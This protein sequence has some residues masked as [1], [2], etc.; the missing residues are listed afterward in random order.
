MIA[1]GIRTTLMLL[2]MFVLLWTIWRIPAPRARSWSLVALLTIPAMAT[3]VYGLLWTYLGEKNISIYLAYTLLELTIVLLL[4]RQQ[5]PTW[6][7]LL[8]IIGLFSLSGFIFN[9]EVNEGLEFMLT[10]GLLEACML[11][12]L[13]LV[14]LWRMAATS[15]VPLQLRPEFWL[16]MGLLIYFGGL[17]P[18]I[19][20]ARI[21]YERDQPLSQALWSILPVLCVIRYVLTAYG[22]TLVARA[23]HKQFHG[24]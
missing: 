16:F 3:E 10:E 20:A 19:G 22:C 15:V 6:S 9:Y 24:R 13:V 23:H 18:V 11:S 5:E 14:I 7:R 21:V 1:L 17:I 4:A 2:S 12:I 8:W